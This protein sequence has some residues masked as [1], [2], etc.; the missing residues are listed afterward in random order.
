MSDIVP[1]S[2]LNKRGVQGVA[3]IAGGIGVLI[4]SAFGGHLIGGLLVG[5]AITIV[6]LAL[7][8]SKNDRTVGLVTAALGAATIISSIP[9][10]R[11]IGGF[12]HGLMVASGIVLLGIGGLSLFRFI[13]GLRKRM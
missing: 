12:F 5:G 7:S 10:L 8:G 13:S 11:G 2:Q 9:F 6:G 4:L 1:R 3:A